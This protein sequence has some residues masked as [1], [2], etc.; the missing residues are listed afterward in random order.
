MESLSGDEPSL[1]TI[2]IGPQHEEIQG[3]WWAI[4]RGE[5]AYAAFG[6]NKEEACRR[7]AQDVGVSYESMYLVPVLASV[8][9]KEWQQRYTEEIGER[10]VTRIIP[11][12]NE[13]WPDDMS[14]LSE[15]QR[16]AFDRLRKG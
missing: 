3:I 6:L 7:V 16:L 14:N 2:Q 8:Y 12:S 15:A 13:P 4:S 1:I 9:D 5:L 10:A 11:F